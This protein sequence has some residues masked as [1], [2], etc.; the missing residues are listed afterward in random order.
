MYELKISFGVENENQVFGLNLAEGNGQKFVVSYDAKTSN[1]T[2]NRMATPFSLQPRWSPKP[3]F[4][5]SATRILDLH[6]FV[7]QSSV[8]RN[9][10]GSLQDQHYLS[11]PSLMHLPMIFLCFRKRQCGSA[12]H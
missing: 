5:L 12:E 3:R 7:D 1:I 11:L 9:T 10:C 6:I 4:Y 2:I 8:Q